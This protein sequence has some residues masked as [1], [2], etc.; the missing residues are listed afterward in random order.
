MRELPREEPARHQKRCGSIF[1]PPRPLVEAIVEGALPHNLMKLSVTP[2]VEQRVSLLAA[3]YYLQRTNPRMTL[4]QR[5]KL[6]TKS[7]PRC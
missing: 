5:A 6:A 7:H 2:H 4:N 3:H 1:C